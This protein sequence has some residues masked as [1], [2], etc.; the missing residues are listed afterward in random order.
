MRGKGLHSGT[1][2]VRLPQEPFHTSS[3]ELPKLLTLHFRNCS[4]KIICVDGVVFLKNIY[5]LSIKALCIETD[6]D[7]NGQRHVVLVLS[8]VS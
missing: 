2:I 6:F 8:L 1:K 5:I 4:D 7:S 3:H